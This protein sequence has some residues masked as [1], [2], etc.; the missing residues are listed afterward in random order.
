MLYQCRSNLYPI[1]AQFSKKNNNKIIHFF[2]KIQ[3][4][5]EVRYLVADPAAGDPE[6]IG[7]AEVAISG[8]K[9]VEDFSLDLG[10]FNSL[11]HLMNHWCSSSS[12]GGRHGYATQKPLRFF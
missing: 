2:L 10:Q 5:E 4:K 6:L 8:E 3:N 11:L 1:A 7:E 12:G 9:S